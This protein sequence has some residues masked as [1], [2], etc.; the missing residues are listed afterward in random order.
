MNNED[1][2]KLQVTF[3]SWKRQGN[4]FALKTPEGKEPGQHLDFRSLTLEL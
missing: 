4:R 3:R 1:G 2:G